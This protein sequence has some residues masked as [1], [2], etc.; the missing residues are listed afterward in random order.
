MQRM[1]WAASAHTATSRALPQPKLAAGHQDRRAAEARLVEHE[2]RVRIAAP[3]GEQRGLVV[4]LERT[5]ELHRRDLIGVD[6]VDQQGRGGAAD[7]W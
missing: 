7:G 6:V 1:P 2:R 5:H 3:A 4:G